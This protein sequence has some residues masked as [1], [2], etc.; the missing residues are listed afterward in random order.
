MPEE[1]K[2]Q[3]DLR[4]MG[5]SVEDIRK[6]FS[7]KDISNIIVAPTYKAI[8]ELREALYV[9]TS[10]T[11]TILGVMAQWPRQ[12]TRGSYSV[13]KHGRYGLNKTDRFRPIRTTWG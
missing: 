13:Y 4:K 3:Q 9:N 1:D 11:P 10:A 12:N 2:E 8:N 7:I 5:I 6:Q